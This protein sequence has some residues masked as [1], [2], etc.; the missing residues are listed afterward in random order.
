M[1]SI[2]SIVLAAFNPTRN[3]FQ[4]QWLRDFEM[5]NFDGGVEIMLSENVSAGSVS[6]SI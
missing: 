2:F 6:F 5:K 1:L 4:F 3:Y